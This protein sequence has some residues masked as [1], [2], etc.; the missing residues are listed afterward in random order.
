[1][2]L[3]SSRLYRL[4]YSTPSY[5]RFLTILIAN[6]LQGV[7]FSLLVAESSKHNRKVINTI[8][9]TEATRLLIHTGVFEGDESIKL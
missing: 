7:P 2:S 8:A 3:L 5:Q 9:V 4:T 6:L 1:M